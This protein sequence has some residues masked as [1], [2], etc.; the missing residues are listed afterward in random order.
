MKLLVI[1]A[2]GR[3]HAIVWALHHTATA[4]MDVFCAPG[5]A[6]I[7]QAATLL[8]VP[9]TDHRALARFAESEQVELTIVG[10]EAPLAAGIVD[11]FEAQGLPI[12]GPG[13]AA[14]RLEAS[15]VFAKDFMARHR[16]PTATYRS[17]E[18]A[19]E[20]L[21]ILRS[22]EFA[23]AGGSVVIKADG[24]AAGK[25]VVVASSPV[26]AEQAIEDLMVN[27]LAGA[28]AAE[29]VIVEEALS[30]REASV[31][32]FADGKDYVIMPPARDHKRIGDDDTGPNTGGMGSI[33]DDGVLEAGLL[34]RVV[35][36]IVE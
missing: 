18:S 24:L 6:G 30:G 7:G 21:Q 1:G 32:L 4:P 14:S 35:S 27:H 16:I 19:Q 15:K 26:E 36:E 13:Q 23:A 20:A 11:L 31:L 5:N 34:Q 25:G 17:A 28:E 12:V 2:G 10:P 29:R 33:T 9:V 8:P 22:G 3:E